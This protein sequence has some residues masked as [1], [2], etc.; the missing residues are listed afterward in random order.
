MGS[1]AGHG[2]SIEGERLD[3]H[4]GSPAAPAR[5]ID[6]SDRLLGALSLRRN[7]RALFV[8]PE[9][10]LRPLDG[11]RALSILWVMLFHAAWY[12]ATFVPLPTYVALLDANLLAEVYLAMTRG[13]DSLMI[14]SAPTPQAETRRA[15]S[16]LTLVVMVATAEELAAIDRPRGRPAPLWLRRCGWG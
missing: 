2:P 4:H 16:E 8:P 13:Q 10:H 15:M 1:S 9:T 3:G 6:V 7:L 11:L 5:A 14:D 12:S